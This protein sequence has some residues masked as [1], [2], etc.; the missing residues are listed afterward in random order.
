MPAG[1]PRTP[2]ISIAP[3]TAYLDAV[4]DPKSSLRQR[5]RDDPLALAENLQLLLP[6]KPVVIMRELGL[7]DSERHGPI[8]PGIRDLVKDVCTLEVTDAVVVGPRGGGK[9]QSVSF[10][11][12][13]LVFILDFDAL[14][15][16]GSELQANNVYKY[17]L[18]YINSH[19]QWQNM[20][21][22]EPLQSE[23]HT[24]ENAWIR[25][26]TASQK[27]VRSPHAGGRK[28]GGRLAGGILV[29]DEEAEAAPDIVDAALPT[30]NTARPS[31]NVRAS[32]FHNAEGTFAEVVEDHENMGYTLYSWDIFDV[33]E[34]CECTGGVCQSPE[35]C[36]RDDHYENVVNP[37]TGKEEQK[38][39]HRAYCGGR[40]QY[41]KGWIPMTEIVKLWRRMKRNHTLWEIEA[42]GSRPVTK[43]HIIRDRVK[44]VA[45]R[46]SLPGSALYVP[47]FPVTVC[48]D[49]GTVAAG[50]SVW[51]EQ[52][53]DRHATLHA[54]LLLQ[55]GSAQ[56][57][58]EIL[59]WQTLYAND[60]LEVAADIGGG[61]NYMNKK[62]RDEMHIPCRDV[63]FEQEKELSIA[64]WNVYNEAGL[65][66]FSEEQEDF[67]DQL[68]KWKRTDAGKIV[69]RKDHLCDSGV[70]YFAKFIDRLGI[71]RVRVAGRSFSSALPP[72]A[73]AEPHQPSTT[74]RSVSPRPRAAIIRGIGRRR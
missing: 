44:L 57:L 43:G 5:Y 21:K 9:S 66:V 20:V 31:V 41:A 26:L 18:A 46:C 37:D 1:R 50:V 3:P 42:M 61:G 58:G 28:P 25:V 4:R 73:A 22:G 70:C 71:S 67:W 30:I 35:P 16:G 55:A 29:I 74:S 17:V 60:F 13:F 62:L 34:G 53:G 38:L 14:N 48:V 56:I 7:Y 32:T 49:W 52:A 47:G 36:F 59:K 12:F 15:L 69:K 24:T 45:N 33:A 6:E 11:Q 51:Q 65:W 40:A 54:E 27:S 63:N 10:I 72:G 19:P 8:T 2:T 23:T 68:K 39:I 64:A